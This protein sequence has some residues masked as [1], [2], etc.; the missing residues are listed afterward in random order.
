MANAMPE[1]ET[2]ISEELVRGLLEEQHPDLLEN[3]DVRFQD[4]G[5]DSAIYRLGDDLAVRMPRRAINAELL[6]DELK[7]LPR[8]APQLPLAI[9][10]PVRVGQPGL[11]YPWMWSVAQWFDGASW[12]D[13]AVDDLIEAAQIFGE[14]VRALGT[15][16]PE[17][18]P[19]NPYRGGPLER[20][21][22]AVRA[23]VEFLGDA[24]PVGVIDLWEELLRTPVNTRRRWLHGDLHPANVIVNKGRLAAVIDWVDL[25]GG[26]T[27]YDLAAAW[28]CFP[29]DV[30]AREVFMAATGETDEA[31]WLRARACAL[32]H[33]IA[34]LASSADNVRMHQVGQRTLHAVLSSRL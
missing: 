8:L 25:S 2:D 14:F 10:E 28:F 21:D 34:C 26:D 31:T 33:A 4:N 24:L 17:D 16:A 15:D 23:R 19:T 30:A 20:R 22:E 32:S 3:R 27:A 18:A 9:N 29:E 5:W 1:A 7:W 12:A 13:A 11:G 6:P